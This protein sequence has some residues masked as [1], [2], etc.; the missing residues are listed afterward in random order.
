MK[1]IIKKWI[2]VLI[3][4]DAGELV[5]SLHTY[6]GNNRVKTQQESDRRDVRERVRTRN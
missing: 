5:L 4:R 6:G 3:G 2:Q 1:D